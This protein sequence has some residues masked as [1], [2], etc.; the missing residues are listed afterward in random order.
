MSSYSLIEHLSISIIL[1]LLGELYV[2]DLVELFQ[3]G[4]LLGLH[5]LDNGLLSH[6]SFLLSLSQGHADVP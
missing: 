5:F 6:P 4:L 3:H 2:L 1:L